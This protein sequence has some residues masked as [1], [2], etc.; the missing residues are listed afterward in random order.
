MVAELLVMMGL[1]PRLGVGTLVIIGVLLLKRGQSILMLECWWSLSIIIVIRLLLRC[2]LIKLSLLLIV[3]RCLWNVL[4]LLLM[5][6]GLI[7]TEMLLNSTII[8]ACGQLMMTGVH[9]SRTHVL[10]ILLGYHWWILIL[11]RDGR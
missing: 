1:L 4:K 3:L 8:V 11:C 9:T 2:H 10:H 5:Q 6:Y 7:L